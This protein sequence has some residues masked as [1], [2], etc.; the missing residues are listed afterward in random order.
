ASY[1]VVRG[2]RIDHVPNGMYGVAV[3]DTSH[4][5]LLDRLT[6]DGTGATHSLLTT[7]P[8]GHHLTL[9]NSTLVNCPASDTGCTYLDSSANLAEVGN[10]FGPVGAS[11]NYDC[12]TVLDVNTGLVDGNWCITTA[13]GFD[14]GM[15]S[16]A[17]LQGVIV[18][19]NVVNGAT[20]RA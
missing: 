7:A 13:D 20:S 10:S 14:E 18:R 17:P 9:K 5:V 6:I 11:G 16:A 4:H 2:F 12:N 1:V 3:V 19:Y 15:H 8:A